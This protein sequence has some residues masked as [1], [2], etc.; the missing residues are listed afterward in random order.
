MKILMVIWESIPFLQKQQVFLMIRRLM[1]R[2]LL[3]ALVTKKKKG[4][5]RKLNRL[6]FFL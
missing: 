5:K 6:L 1:T 2:I 4:E 3:T